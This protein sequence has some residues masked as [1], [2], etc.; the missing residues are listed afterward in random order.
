MPNFI[1]YTDE[2]I[3]ALINDVY[4][5]VV[6]RD[7]LPVDLYKDIK[8]RLNKAVFEGFGGTYSDFSTA[9]SD[10]LIMAGFEKN[11][12]VFSGAKTFQQVN[13]MSNF[14]FAGKDKIPF[15]EFKKYANDIFDTYNDNWLKT[16]YNT[17]L[18][19]A[20]SAQQ[21]H[22]IKEQA[23]IFPLI[24]FITVGDER[25]RSNHKQLDEIVRPI[26]DPFWKHN[27]PPLDWN[28]RCTT[29]QLEEG[30]EELTDLGTREIPSVPKLFQMNA[31]EDKVIFDESVHPY[32]T[33]DKRYK[34]ALGGNFGLPFVSEVKAKA[35][36]IKKAPAPAVEKGFKEITKRTEFKTR[37]VS[38]FKDKL[39]LNMSDAVKVSS[40]LDIET[41]NLNL[42]TVENLLDE[43]DISDTVL[44][45]ELTK[46]SFASTNSN[47]GFVQSATHRQKGSFDYK[48]TQLIEI[49]FGSASDTGAS[50]TFDPL[51]RFTRSKSR[52]D[53]ENQKIATIVHEFGHVIVTDRAHLIQGSKGAEFIKKAVTLRN[54]YSAELST[55]HQLE[56]KT[57]L[58]K[59]SLGKYAS[60]NVN[61]FIAEAFTEYKLSSNPSKYAVELGK[62]IDEY[63]KKK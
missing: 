30:E 55:V 44:K 25:V 1:N 54:Q 38:A 4:K 16:E 27:F 2:Q 6:T 7:N 29:E 24:K 22:T 60:T 3:E 42:K 43:Y 10:G 49:N 57:E 13:D 12:A 62:L 53:F 32:F 34:V 58:M 51:A 18:S 21:W 48:G 20:S 37:I 56:D 5:G 50:R 33:V 8:R 36:R 28:C 15:S 46:V 59:L 35:V 52:V 63:F 47:Y 23:E 26:G 39:G 45:E 14:L 41:L 19:Q 40:K 11:I 31:G 9:T 61:E 17:A